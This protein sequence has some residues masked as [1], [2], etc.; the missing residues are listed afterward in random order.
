MY[1]RRQ[2]RPKPRKSQT[3][4]W[5]APVAGWVANRNLADPKAIEGPGA[6]VL[7]NF[8][9]KSSS[10]KLRRGKQLYATLGD[11][12]KPV[13]SIFSYLD[14]EN[15][16]IFAT[17]DTTIYNITSVVFPYGFEVVDEDEQLIVTETGDYFGAESTD[18]FEVSEDHLGG[19]WITVQFATT[20]DVYL[21]GVNG[22]DDGFIFDGED[23]WPNIAGGILMQAVDGVTTPFVVGETVTGVISGKTAVVFRVVNGAPGT[24]TLYLRDA[25]GAFTDNEG[26]DGSGGGEGVINGASTVASP[27]VTFPDGYTTADMSYVW[28]YKNRLWFARKNSMDAYYLPVDA[29]GGEATLFPLA[30]IFGRGG[31]LMFGASWS[32][33]AGADAGLS[34]QNIFVSSEGEVAIFQGSNPEDASDW[35]KVG[36]YRV[37]RPLGPR[38]HFRGG[39]D[40][41]IATS[42]GLV[43]LSKAISLD[44]TSLSVGT[45]SY[46]IADAWSDA[47]TLRGLTDWQCEVWPEQKMAIVSPPDLI[48]ST[49][50]VLF[51][52]NTETGA[53]ARYT[54]WYAL[55]M[56]VFQGQLYFGS[57]DGK[58]FLGNVSGKDEEDT[59]TGTILPL[60]DD[61]G[62]PSS[63][64]IGTMGRAVTRANTVV[65]GRVELRGDYNQSFGANPDATFLNSDNAWG[66]GIWGQA[67]W[68]SAIPTVINQG[69]HSTGGTG[70]ALSMSY[71]VTSGSVTP[72]DD[73]LIRMEMLYTTAE[74]V[75]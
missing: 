71:R 75:T 49:E 60:F 55:A 18:G 19:Y 66:S 41:A 61:V 32:L 26:L 54:G 7:D 34:E 22:Q 57:P 53:W 6:A 40:I 50:P 24:Q 56:E 39:G 5:A 2:T 73:E 28:A 9:P 1:A 64:K 37:G 10:V 44:I 43:P 23:F 52:S 14:G 25:T 47:V 63:V 42:V 12:T 59:Y 67:V 38:A 4:K 68:G 35:R 16:R 65:K 51:I 31:T 58:I 72:L 46:K 33:D 29:V 48:G 27:G 11:G 30:G 21:I 36:L 3:Y 69:W 8:F 45:V 62:S 70:Y 20:G 13:T 17:T 15:Q 74:V